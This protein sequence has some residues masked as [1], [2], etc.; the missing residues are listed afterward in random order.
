MNRMAEPGLEIAVRPNRNSSLFGNGEAKIPVAESHA[1]FDRPDQP[2]HRI[3]AKSQGRSRI[4]WV[5]ALVAIVCLA[6]ALGAGLGAG[7]TAQR[8]SN[9]AR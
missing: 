2:N 6:V 3:G 1:V 9:P 7:L 4:T 8:K 5:L